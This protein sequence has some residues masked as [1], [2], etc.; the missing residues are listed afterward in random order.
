[1]AL[2]YDMS[3]LYSTVRNISG[4]TK[5][6]P[7][8]PPHGIELEDD[9]E[10]TIFGDVREAIFRGGRR[11]QHVQDALE[12][13]LDQQLLEIVHTPA[14]LLEDVTSGDIKLLQVDGGTLGVD[15]PCWETSLS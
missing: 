4:G 2:T 6:F 3:C 11:S 15:D 14:V 1:M 5:R 10:T 7:F 9:G 8:L 12:K 13:C